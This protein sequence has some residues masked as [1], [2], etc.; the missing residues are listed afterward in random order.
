M[1]ASFGKA[2]DFS[3]LFRGTVDK[4]RVRTG[5]FARQNREFLSA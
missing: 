1:A 4:I 2:S 5:N 3:R